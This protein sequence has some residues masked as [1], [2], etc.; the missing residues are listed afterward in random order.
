MS[1]ESNNN[2]QSQDDQLSGVKKRRKSDRQNG[3]EG[4]KSSGTNDKDDAKKARFESKREKGSRVRV[5][6]RTDPVTSDE[7]SSEDENDKDTEETETTDSQDSSDGRDNPSVGRK[8]VSPGSESEGSRDKEQETDEPMLSVEDDDVTT[9]DFEALLDQNESKSPPDERSFSTGDQVTG[10]IVAVGERHIFVDLGSK[11]EG[12]VNRSEFEDEE[13][14]IDVETGEVVDFYVL[15]TD[16][17]EILLGN[18]LK[19]R[20]G[21]MKIVKE[22]FESEVPIEGKVVESNSGGFVVD[23]NG[24]RAFCPI[25]QIELGY[26]E[27][28]EAHVGATYRF[29]VDDIEGRDVVLNRSKLLAEERAQQREET[30]EKLHEG[31]TI[32]GVVTRVANFGAFVDLG[33]VEGLVHI[34]ELSHGHLDDASEVVDAGDT[35]TTKV[36]SIDEDEETDNPRISLSIKETEDN[37]W[38]KVNELFA[39]GEKVEGEVVRLAPF[40]AFVEVADGIDGLVHVSE[41]SWEKHVKTPDEVVSVGDTVQVEVQDI[42]LA[43]QRMSLSMKEAE[44]DPWEAAA[45]KYERGMTIEGTVENIEDF[46]TFVNLERG[47]TALLPR[48]EMDLPGNASPHSQFEV[49]DDLE[50][51]VLEVKSDQQKMALTLRDAEDLGSSDSE[52]DDSSED[53]SQSS[54]SDTDDGDSGGF[55]TLGDMIGDDL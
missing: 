39:V 47:I 45:D 23:I 36:L 13:G 26:T 17:D 20:E 19:G 14:N 43:K 31:A 10:E 48:S 35:V 50:A 37:P 42:D 40:G 24:V 51:R 3:D 49:G 32:D 41:M 34:S 9:Q 2:E 38:Q 1:N 54:W 53:Q 27:E 15:S 52:G 21:N 25:S 28:K 6:E 5:A 8:V 16:G 30:M 29:R 44:G 11:S 46:G 12:I 33:G 18:E 55:G 7:S 22:A 4:A